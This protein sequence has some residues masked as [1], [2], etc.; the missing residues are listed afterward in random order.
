MSSRLS[1]Q[2][3]FTLLELLVALVVL[4]FV[5]SGLAGG[6]QLAVAS[7]RAQTRFLQQHQD[8]QPVDQLM[9]RL[10]ADMVLPGDARQAGL[11]GKGQSL[12]CITKL[13]GI[14]GS[15]IRVDALV[16]VDAEHRLVLQWLP[17]VHAQRLAPRAAPAT[18]ILLA[19]VRQIE[20]S[21]LSPAGD[22]WLS[23]WSRT[24]LPALIRV[25]LV[26]PPGDPRRWPPM[27]AATLQQNRPNEGLSG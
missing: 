1:A 26:F 21:Y 13:P 5:I 6:T 15:V 8:L 7:I 14:N 3:G 24:D 9:R 20:F 12:T 11:A 23:T 18:E 27:I 16:A 17:H 4:G 25:E 22:G 19:R 10:I 2:A